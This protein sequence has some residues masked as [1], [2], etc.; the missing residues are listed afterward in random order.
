[1][2]VIQVRAIQR[3]EPLEARP[4]TVGP[5][6]PPVGSG[7]FRSIVHIK[8][9]TR[10]A[11]QFL[12]ATALWLSFETLEKISLNVPYMGGSQVCI[13]HQ[14]INA[15]IFDVNSLNSI[16]NVNWFGFATK[17]DHN[18]WLC[19]PRRNAWMLLHRRSDLTKRIHL[20]VRARNQE[21]GAAKADASGCDQ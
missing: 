14:N 4:L 12:E 5:A 10:I 9:S 6:L 8:T 7:R 16:P 3:E 21:I 19:P 11:N 2:P 17:S 20:E 15:S 1:M 18:I 13:N